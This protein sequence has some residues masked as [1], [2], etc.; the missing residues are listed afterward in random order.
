MGKVIWLSKAGEERMN[1]TISNVETIA[2][3]FLSEE[4]MT[5]KKL[6]K[7]CYYAYSWYLT[8]FDD[9]LFDDGKFQ[10]W[11]HGPVNVLL[12]DK[13]KRYGWRNIPMAVKPNLDHQLS[14]FL[15]MILNTYKE[16][17]G[18]QMENMTHN[19]TP[20]I[21]ARWGLA[22]EQPSN[23][24]INDI[25]IKNFYYKLMEDGQVE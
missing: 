22:P 21:E 13:Y 9:Y 23:N 25:T 12:Y 11:V 19:E 10:A 17:D 7:I 3:Y 6:Q 18:N 14:E 20:W 4:S 1:N 2:N 15:D 16:F 5:P 8:L 24:V